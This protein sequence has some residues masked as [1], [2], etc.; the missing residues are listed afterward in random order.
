MDGMKRIDTFFCL[1]LFTTIFSVLSLS[2]AKWT[3]A[4]TFESLN[5]GSAGYTLLEDVTVTGDL[6]VNGE[7]FADILL[8]YHTI[9]IVL[10]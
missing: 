8:V 1:F 7:V 5:V 6:T 2:G 3:Y 4:A 10:I 9:G